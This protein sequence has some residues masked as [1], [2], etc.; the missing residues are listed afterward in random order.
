M[1][2]DYNLRLSLLKSGKNR[3]VVR[4]SLN[5]IRCQ[6][7]EYGDKGDRTL[8]EVTSGALKKFGW[9][10]HTG[11]IPAAYLTGMLAGFAALKK[12]I[13]EAVLDIGMQRSSKASVLFACA[14]GAAESGIIIPLGEGAVPGKDRITGKHISQFAASLKK[15]QDK[16][17]RQFAEYVKNG[18]EPE[19]MEEYF[20]STQGRIREE[21]K[22][23]I[24]LSQFEETAKKFL[25]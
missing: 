11:N 18:I 23:V 21:F 9:K 10:A 1:K 8:V 6:F 15:S 20:N 13:K 19:R 3:L 24:K 5:G 22:D 16:Y 17:K 14:A 2:T 4:R 25:K 7:V 12:G